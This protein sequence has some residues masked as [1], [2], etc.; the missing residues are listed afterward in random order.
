MLAVEAAVAVLLLLATLEVV[1]RFPEG[2]EVE[3]IL[4]TKQ[5]IWK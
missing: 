5:F 1:L 4:I 3:L 2:F